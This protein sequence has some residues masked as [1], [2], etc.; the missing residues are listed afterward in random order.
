MI[1]SVSSYSTVNWYS[2]LNTQKQQS[3]KSDG[4]TSSTNGIDTF[5]FSGQAYWPEDGSE[6]KDPLESLVNDGTI[7][8][9][10]A[11]QIGQAL[12]SAMESGWDPG[13][14]VDPLSSLVS[15]GAIT[16]D[17]SSAVREVLEANRPEAQAKQFMT[18]VLDSLVSSGTLTSDQASAV[19]EALAKGGPQGP[20]GPGG[21]PPAPPP[22]QVSGSDNEESVNLTG[23][24]EEEILAMLSA[25]EIN[26]QQAYAALMKLA[27]Y[28][29]G[30]ESQLSGIQPVE[31]QEQAGLLDS[32]VVDGTITEDQ[33]SAIW[34]AFRQAKDAGKAMQAYTST[35]AA[36][37]I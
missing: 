8:S 4:V 16:N 36:S 35:V 18:G 31:R 7:T 6:R 25:G 20:Q 14:G 2:L 11:S 9:A 22:Q 17:Q 23:K 12:R 27:G 19:Q 33:Q 21:K 24:T 28:G 10:Q 5:D 32:L 34:T 29:N 3:D 15:S 30:D 26:S 1:E 37:S 13:S